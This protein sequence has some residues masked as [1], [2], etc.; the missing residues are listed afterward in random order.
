MIKEIF[1]RK[2]NVHFYLLGLNQFSEVCIE[3]YNSNATTCQQPFTK[4]IC[5]VGLCWEVFHHFFIWLKMS[6]SGNKNETL[7][8]QS[9]VASAMIQIV[10]QCVF[11]TV[12]M[13]VE[14]NPPLTR[15]VLNI[16]RIDFSPH[17]GSH[18]K[19]RGCKIVFV[20]VRCFSPCTNNTFSIGDWR[21]HRLQVK[22]IYTPI[23]QIKNLPQG[24]L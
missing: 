5:R 21:A 20:H 13:Q 24:A 16:I 22:S 8:T 7:Q 12:V 14:T 1:W 11:S 9:I 2:Q 10:S 18:Q 17:V 6:S 15:K 19:M 23:S 3:L 4:L